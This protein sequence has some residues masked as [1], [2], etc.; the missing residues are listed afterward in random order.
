MNSGRQ[1]GIAGIIDRIHADEDI[2]AGQHFGPS[3]RERQKNS[4]A[5]GNVGHRNAVADARFRH[6][7]IRR[8]RRSAKRAQ[9]DRHHAMLRRAQARCHTRRRF[10]LRAMPLA[11]IETQ[12]V[13]TVAFAPRNGQARRR[14]QAAA[15]QAD[16]GFR[17]VWPGSPC[18]EN[19]YCLENLYYLE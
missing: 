16:C 2:G 3:Q 9:I 1:S 17:A 11:I 6:R 15:Q 13:A 19:F 5:R 18:W 12:R 14:I 7:D 4:V 10:Q 8:E